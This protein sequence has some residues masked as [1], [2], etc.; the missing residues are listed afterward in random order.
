MRF[1]GKIQLEARG[2]PFIKIISWGVG[3]AM[4]RHRYGDVKKKRERPRQHQDI[5]EKR[6]GPLASAGSCRAQRKTLGCAA[7]SASAG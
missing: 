3:G 2:F 6:L 1:S 5:G 7:R 4:S